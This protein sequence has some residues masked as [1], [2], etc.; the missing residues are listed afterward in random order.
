[1]SAGEIL[2]TSDARIFIAEH[3]AGCGREYNYYACMKVGSVNKSYGEATP[4]YC[5]GDIAGE[6]IQTDSYRGDESSWTTDLSGYKPRGARSPLQ[7]MSKRKSPIDIQVHFG[8]CGDL[9]DFSAYESAIIFE[10]VT[11]SGHTLDSLGALNAGETAPIM[12]S[13]KLSAVSAYEVYCMKLL[14]VARTV[15]DTAVI[16]DVTACAESCAEE[17]FLP[18]SV[19][20]AFRFAGV[21]DEEDGN[22]VVIMRSE[23]G[24]IT[25]DDFTFAVPTFDPAA[26]LHSF[27]IVCTGK[28]VLLIGNTIDDLGVVYRIAMEDLLDGEAT[29]YRTATIGEQINDV[30]YVAGKVYM[31][32]DEGALYVLSPNTLSTTTIGLIDIEAWTYISVLDDDHFMVASVLGTINVYRRGVVTSI[33]CLTV[34]GIED[35]CQISAIVM[36]SPTEWYVATCGGK[37]HCTINGGKTWSTI[38]DATAAIVDL[39]FPTKNVGYYLTRSPCQIY[40]TIDGGASWN[41]IRDYNSQVDASTGYWHSLATCSQDPNV[42]VAT[43]RNPNGEQVICNEPEESCQHTCEPVDA[44]DTG[45]LVSGQIC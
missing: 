39:K 14:A 35:N 27:H 43:G 28:A 25:W 37:L 20:Y 18:C 36:R 7:R 15:T 10:D 12:E 19:F 8:R 45:I 17:C 42:F 5:P 24:G 13:V 16:L 33:D 3:G 1:M 2:L 40:R 34:A 6:F 26:A 31:A 29:V 23:D 41:P 44:A 9:S 22:S 30:A 4:V 32:G 21:L 11:L 38:I